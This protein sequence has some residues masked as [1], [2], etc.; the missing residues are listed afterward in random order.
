VD[1]KAC[2]KSGGTVAA[3]ISADVEKGRPNAQFGCES[4][5]NS[6]Y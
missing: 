6:Q 1:P 5:F 2:L 3:A 4:Y